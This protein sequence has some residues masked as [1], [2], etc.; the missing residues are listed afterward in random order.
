MQMR[1]Y[2]YAI[3]HCGG[4]DTVLHRGALG[5]QRVGTGVETHNTT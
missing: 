3:D 5:M 2:Q 4:I 1:D